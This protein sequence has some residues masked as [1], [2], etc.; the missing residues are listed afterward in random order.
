MMDNAATNP[1]QPMADCR[2]VPYKPSPGEVKR[3]APSQITRGTIMRQ[4]LLV[5]SLVAV[6]FLPAWPIAAQQPPQPKKLK[7]LLVSGG[8]SHKWN[9]VNPVLTKKIPDFANVTIDAKIAGEVKGGP[10][11][12]NDPKFAD[13]Y[14]V[15]MYNCCFA[16]PSGPDQIENCLKLTRAG[17]PMVVIHCGVHSFKKSLEWQD[18]CGMTSNKHDPYR[19]FS[20]L[21]VEE[22]PV[23]KFLPKDWK[24]TGDE[25]YQTIKMGE[26]SKPLLRGNYDM[27]KSDH[28]ICWV[29]N[30]G[31][32]KVF[33]TTLGH[34]LKTVNMAEYHHLLANG[35]LWACDKL[36][37]D[38]KPLEGFGGPS[39]K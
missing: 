36:D 23:V 2:V 6:G 16:D 10:V 27:G 13:G 14:D 12:L 15:I 9:E 5:L 22:H 38:G 34:D 37:K 29:S 17:K 21:K 25:L 35:L 1:R 11:L 19:A 7:A 28:T 3:L 20:V 26:R 33:A 4:V 39:S 8:G 24:T 30:Y 31:K 18:C 32:G